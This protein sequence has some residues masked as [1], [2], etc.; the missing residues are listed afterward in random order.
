MRS[1]RD[2]PTRLEWREPGGPDDR[3]DWSGPYAVEE[4]QMMSDQ[5]VCRAVDDEYHLRD[6]G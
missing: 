4:R 3:W 1:L 6:D 5:G 2:A